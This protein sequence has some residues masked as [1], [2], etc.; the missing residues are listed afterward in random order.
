M[1]RV[2][3]LW[4]LI[5]ALVLS[6]LLADYATAQ[7][8]DRLS[9]TGQ[10][11]QRTEYSA[12][13][14]N[15][16]QDDPL[17]S[18]LRT[19]IN[20]GVRA[21]EDVK[22]FVQFQDSRVWGQENST[23]NGNA[24]LF[25]VHQAYFTVSNVFDTG[26]NAKVGRQE[27]N[28]GNQRLVGAV[29]WH[30]VGRSFDAARFMYKAEKGSLDIFAARLVGSTG[31]PDGD[32]LFGAVGTYPIDDGKRIE[33]LVLFDN[34][35]FPIPAGADADENTLSRITAGAAA[36]G[37]EA[38]FD[39]EL[40]GYYQMGDAFEAATGELGS[41]AA[42]LASAKVGYLVNEENGM[43]VG[44]LFT[45]VSGDDDAADGDINNFNT[46]FAT[47]HKFYGFMDYFIGAGS[48]ARGLQD[49]GLSFGMKANDQTSISIDLHNFSAPQ[50][51]A[52]ADD[53]LGNEIDFT[54]NH[55]YN[56]ALTIVAG[57]SAFMPGDD[58]GGEDT[59]FWGY[60]STIVNF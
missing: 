17:F 20:V 22:A 57:L 19:R 37:K 40:E 60:L 13:D 36:Y 33:A 59:A 26:F 29:G 41:I 51:P 10:I 15:A 56:S 35:T 27:I 21:N 6:V 44:G 50:A 16:D 34:S 9:V 3:P 38:G 18:F 52:G 48:F 4:T 23:L 54:V 1:K 39:F 28:V 24:P 43:R 58:F 49:L 25:D 2:L 5:V 53:V 55:K 31:T 11:R 8:T 7:S 46:L 42:Y 30:N 45:I 14:F 32:N 47:N 12:K